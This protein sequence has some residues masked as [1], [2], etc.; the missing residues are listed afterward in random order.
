MKKMALQYFTDVDLSMLA[1]WIFFFAF[2]FLIF[3]VYVYEKKETFDQL[4]QIPLQD[5]ESHH[6]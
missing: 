4:S 6:G 2:L 3:R 5:E 1:L